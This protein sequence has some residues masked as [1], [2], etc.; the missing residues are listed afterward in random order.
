MLNQNRI[1]IIASLV[2]FILSGCAKENSPEIQK[3]I[4]EVEK[5]RLEKNDYMKN[6]P[7]SP[8]NFKGKVEFHPLKYYEV[9]P[10]FKF[11]SKLIQYDP[12][13]T[14]TILGTKGEERKLLRY[15]YFTFTNSDKEFKLNVYE[16]TSK[17]GEVYHMIQFTDRTTGEDTYGVGRY[18]DFELSPD[19]DFVYTIDFNLAYNP[20]CA[21]SK[22]YSCAIPTKE[23]HLDLAI[24]AG[25]KNYH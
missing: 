7:S 24:E 15:G 6:D 2:V 10:D 25:E 21:Y 18:I 14:V 23:D 17:K 19:I 8:F 5:S 16:G 22:D 4:D 12:M 20:Y 1:L 11:E 13:D 3:Y 9:N